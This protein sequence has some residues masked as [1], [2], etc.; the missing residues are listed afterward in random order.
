VAP[1]CEIASATSF[2]VPVVCSP[3]TA[4]HLQDG[5]QHTISQGTSMSAPHVTGAAA[6]LF[7]AYGAVDAAFIKGWVTSHAVADEFS[8]AVPNLDWGY[9]KLNLST[10]HTTAV[11]PSAPGLALA[12]I[13]P[14]P[15][16]GGKLRVDF[17]LPRAGAVSIA[18]VDVRGRVAQRLARGTFSEG[19]H[20]I[21]A[22]LERVAPGLYFVTLASDA[23]K[24]TRRVIVL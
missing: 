3:A 6:L 17:V 19:P 5:M 23:G 15:F 21:T 7:Q 13:R 24:A 4:F 14:N 22:P 2:D 9:G 8:G 11:A 12:P 18:I 1:G 16:R 20:A 10:L